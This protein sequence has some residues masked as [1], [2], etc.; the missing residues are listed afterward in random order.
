MKSCRSVVNAGR[1]GAVPGRSEGLEVVAD[2]LEGIRRWVFRVCAGGFELRVDGSTILVGRA[3]SRVVSGAIV[4]GGGGA[5]FFAWRELMLRASPNTPPPPPPSDFG[6]R[7]LMVLLRSVMAR[8]KIFGELE[9]LGEAEA[10][11]LSL[12]LS[13]LRPVA[14][15]SASP[16]RPKA[17]VFFSV[18]LERMLLVV[19]ATERWERVRLSGGGGMRRA[20]SATVDGGREEAREEVGREVGREETEARVVRGGEGSIDLEVVGGGSSVWD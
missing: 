19:E 6:L 20:S 11:A 13:L 10:F 8:E 2:A 9:L 3:R 14:R 4:G 15:R 18:V 5:S 12:R 16:A 7:S 17:L 1:L